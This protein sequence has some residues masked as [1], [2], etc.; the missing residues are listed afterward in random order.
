MAKSQV[1]LEPDG[2]DGIPALSLTL[3]PQAN[4]FFFCR[5]LKKFIYFY[6]IYF[7]LRWVFVAVCRFSLVAASGGYSSLRCAG[8]SL[9]WLLL[10]RSRG[11]RRAG[12]SSCGMWA[13]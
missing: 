4:Y 9:R 6:F 8:F 5:F 10:L 13:Q 7:W 3:W 1:P 12:F 11:S 2:S